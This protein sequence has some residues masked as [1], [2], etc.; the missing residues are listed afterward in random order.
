M[1][2]KRTSELID[3]TSLDKLPALEPE[4]FKFAMEAAFA[5]STGQMPLCPAPNRNLKID[6][7]E[8][9][10]NI[11]IADS[12][13]FRFVTAI[14]SHYEED[15]ISVYN[16]VFRFRALNSIL[17]SPLL[18]EWRIPSTDPDSCLVHPAVFEAA[19]K[20]PLNRKGKFD[21]MQFFEEVRRLS[22]KKA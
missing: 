12:S 2:E 15:E 21:E 22:N 6:D 8:K 20:V 4:S 5:A 17:K 11:E 10:I 16:A 18:E 14:S 19:A 1:E 3:I 7:G 13:L 9:V